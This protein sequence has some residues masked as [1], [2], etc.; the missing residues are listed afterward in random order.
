VISFG[1]GFFLPGEI[2]MTEQRIQ[3]VEEALAMELLSFLHESIGQILD[4]EDEGEFL[5]W[6]RAEAPRRLPGLFADL[7]NEQ[8]ARSITFE[9]GRE[10]W[11]LVPLPGA[12]YK[13][14]PIPRPERNAP[15]PCGSGQKHKKCCGATAGGPLE[16]PFQAEDVWALVLSRMP[17]AEVAQLAADRRVPRA[18][19]PGIAERLI[20][21]GG[22]ETAL[23]LLEPL[24]EEPER[25]DERDA[26]TLDALIEAY[27]ALRL[28]ES[29]ERAI[30][31]LDSAL[32]PSLRLVLWE[33]LA[34]SF[35]TR[36]DFA[37]A[38]EAAHR[39]RSADPDSPV[40]GWVEV[41]LYL[42]EN[43]LSV[44]SDR[45]RDALSRHQRRPGLSDEALSLLQET[46]EDAAASRRHLLL[47]DLL[48]SI[49]R[50][51]KL[52]ATLADQPVR[53]YTVRTQGEI[54][55]TG[56]LLAPEDFYAVEEGWV[57]VAAFE[58]EEDEEDDE[59]LALDGKDEDEEE[60]WEE[61]EE[62]DEEDWE[63]EEEEEDEGEEG[64][65]QAWALDTSDEDEEEDGWMSD[66]EEAWSPEEADRWLTWL[67]ENPQAFDSLLVLSDLV[68]R[69]ASLAAE[70]DIELRQTL[71]P[72]LVARGVAILDA[73]L[74]GAP[75]VT[76][77]AH[78]EENL[79]ALEIL[80]ISAF[81]TQEPAPDVEP[82]ER[83]L[84]LDP[85]D[86][87]SVRG[88][89]GTAYLWRREPEKA[90]DLVAR[91]PDHD[92]PDLAFAKVI[93]LWQLERKD[94]A[95]AA[96]DEA[97]EFHPDTGSEIAGSS[98]WVSEALLKLWQNDDE[99]WREL[100]ERVE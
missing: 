56:R 26:D 23:S 77:P 62:D 60:D 24:F 85:E 46:A 19:L 11:N 95:L 84:R 45:A 97:L 10:I 33:A 50:F 18:L 41:I 74:A 94:E 21:F 82:L 43:R 92:I 1:A 36:G 72:P 32:P 100:R 6:V 35:T 79:P 9:I 44:A 8:A 52:L 59:E 75:Q 86:D 81:L 80:E 71:L 27:D 34:R 93:A 73:S 17:E 13:T 68:E 47:D 89:L 96:L 49:E 12:G 55:G 57:A 25:L 70:R 30:T 22:A 4:R 87:L 7:P 20:D 40:L 69:V 78:L 28:D 98:S 16:L 39:I 3:A 42:V 63:D 31:R 29:K 64:E 58:P 48:P 61:G 2:A 76:L 53:P 90:L 65:G 51:E 91:Y 67:A 38:W 37:R 5:A 14:R 83:L 15:C 66:A 99:L 88:D 54:P